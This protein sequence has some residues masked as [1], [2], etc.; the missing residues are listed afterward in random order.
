MDGVER[1]I[2]DRFTHRRIHIE[3]TEFSGRHTRDVY[4]SESEVDLRQ[5]EILLLAIVV[6]SRFIPKIDRHLM[7]NDGMLRV[8]LIFDDEG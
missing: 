4:F 1:F 5:N 6:M 7:E 3:Q 8:L 2:Y